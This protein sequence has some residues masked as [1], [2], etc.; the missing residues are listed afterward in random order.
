MIP[1]KHRRGLSVLCMLVGFVTGFCG[2]AEILGR[3]AS[4]TSIAFLFQALL[5][6]TI[7]VIGWSS[8]AS[9]G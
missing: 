1:E 3:S 9:D 8:G 6:F 5:L 4:I 7:G 2:V